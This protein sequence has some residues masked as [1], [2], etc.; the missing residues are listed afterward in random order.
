MIQPVSALLPT[1]NEYMEAL[2]LKDKFT[3][4][5][6]QFSHYF[7]ILK[8]ME[9]QMQVVVLDVND[10]LFKTFLK[11]YPNKHKMAPYSFFYFLFFI[12]PSLRKSRFCKLIWK[13]VVYPLSKAKIYCSLRA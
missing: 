7:I 12:N 9:S 11:I 8:L 2:K 5:K 10:D 1:Q 13:S 3:P 4:P 6:K